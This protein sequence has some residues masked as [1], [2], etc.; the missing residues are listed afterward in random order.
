M[1]MPSTEHYTVYTYEEIPPNETFG[2]YVSQLTRN[3]IRC[4]DPSTIPPL[5]SE[6]LPPDLNSAPVQQISQQL[7]NTI[8]H[9]VFYF[10]IALQAIS[11]KSNIT[12]DMIAVCVPPFT[13]LPF[14][15]QHHCPPSV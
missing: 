3:V 1:L 9:C 11:I 13:T 2:H 8:G 14:S 6:I 10:A 5:M 15:C 7:G 12:F 4:L